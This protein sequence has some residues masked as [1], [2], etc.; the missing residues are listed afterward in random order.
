[1]LYIPFPFKICRLCNRTYLPTFDNFHRDRQKKDKQCYYCKSCTISRASAYANLHRTEAIGRVNQWRAKNPAKVHG[2]Q[3]AYRL[4]NREKERERGRV[5]RSKHRDKKHESHE[6][7]RMKN[8]SKQR[9][10][11]RNWQRKNPDRG[12]L[13]AH[14][15]RS[16]KRELPAT[17][18]EAQWKFS[19][20]YFNG[21]CAYCGN[22]PSF[23]DHN[24]VLQQEHFVPLVKG[25]SFSVENILPACQSCNYSKG[26]QDPE[27]WVIKRFGKRRAQLALKHIGDYFAAA[28]HQ[29][30][31]P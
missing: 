19:V 5:Y 11:I 27:E 22:P 13:A 14:R 16:R 1:M 9:D 7:W 20:E 4:N 8:P 6:R 18:N 10:A 3:R 15:R 25:G 28:R 30:T 17:F 21:V 26:D 2:Y 12:R 29:F 24:R 23:F 31:H